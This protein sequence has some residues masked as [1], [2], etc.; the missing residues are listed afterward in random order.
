MP[1]TDTLTCEKCGLT[2]EAPKGSRRKFCDEC[3]WEMEL[4][5]PKYQGIKRKRRRF[6]EP[7]QTIDEI[8][9]EMRAYNEEHGTRLSYGKFVAYKAI[10]RIL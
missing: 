1:N 10:G 6:V 7:K 5:K 9:A 3:K 8:L 4:E 2:F